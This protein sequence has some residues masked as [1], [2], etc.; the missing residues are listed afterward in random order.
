MMEVIFRGRTSRGECAGTWRKEG[1]AG[2][3]EGGRAAFV[4]PVGR[5]HN[6]GDN[7]GVA[8]RRRAAL[9]PSLGQQG[10]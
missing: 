3:K 2:K 1:I 4:A 5:L 8:D 7:D 9:W 10:L 6:R